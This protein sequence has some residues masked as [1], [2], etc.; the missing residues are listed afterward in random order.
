MGK[1]IF[2][3]IYILIFPALILFLSGDWF[4]T[5]GWIFGIWFTVLCFSTIIYLYRKDPALLEERYKKP[6]DGNQKGWDKYVVYGLVIA[7]VSWIIIMP[8]DAKRYVWS[9]PFPL[10]IKIL[11]G[12]ELLISF[13]LFFRSFTDN[14]FLSALVRIQSERKQQ[15]V[16]TGVYGFVRHPMYL[17]GALL[18]LGTPMLLG[19]LFGIII[20][21]LVLFLLAGR[22]IGEEKMLMNEL[23]GY[24]DYK[25]KV[26]YRLIPFVW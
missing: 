14:T 4:W 19:S 5:E 10:A 8:L 1:V 2:T 7:F 21:V 26:K 23:E 22:I 11:G 25:K 20:G 9:M 16:T 18:F 3:L 13:F 17:G 12:I 15:V 24:D 6:G